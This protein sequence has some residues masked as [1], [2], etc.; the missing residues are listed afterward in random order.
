MTYVVK[1]FVLK[2]L[3]TKMSM[4]KMLREKIPDMLAFREWWWGAG[5]WI[6]LIFRR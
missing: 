4:E 2:K 6:P 3:A 5:S 1:M